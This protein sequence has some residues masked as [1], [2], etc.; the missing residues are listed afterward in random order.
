MILASLNHRYYEKPDRNQN[1]AS[2]FAVIS[3][4]RLPFPT[5][6]CGGERMRRAPSHV[7][8][9]RPF[10][11]SFVMFNVEQKRRRISNRS[12]AVPM[13]FEFTNRPSS[14]IKPAWAPQ[15]RMTHNL[16]PPRLIP[17]HFFAGDYEE[18]NPPPSPVSLQN[19]APERSFTPTTEPYL[20]PATGPH[21]LSLPPWQPPPSHA[22]NPDVVDVD[23][24]EVSPNIPKT[25]QQP[26]EDS[27]SKPEK[28]SMVMAP[29]HIRRVLRSRLGKAASKQ[30]DIDADGADEGSV[31]NE[32]EEQ[33]DREGRVTGHPGPT[34]TSTRTNN[35]YT[36]NLASSAP[37]AKSDLPYT[38]SGLV[39]WSNP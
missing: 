9:A 4:L 19:V 3:T 2:S 12:T 17:N 32:D 20:F 31:I 23:M 14:N 8:G 6:R 26:R 35:H 27:P 15:E 13:D 33:S 21:P 30:R 28:E 25:H 37:T 22:K 24:S 5:T 11:L 38:L 10:T 7:I 39:L 36:L 29:G 16:S 18:R 34:M 1:V